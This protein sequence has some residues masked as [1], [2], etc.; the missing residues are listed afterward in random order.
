[1][2]FLSVN[3]IAEAALRFLPIGTP[4]PTPSSG[5]ILS[6]GRSYLSLAPWVT[7]FPGLAIMA[8]VLSLN[9]LGDALRDII[10]PRRR[11]DR[12]AMRRLSRGFP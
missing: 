11:T 9:L 6:D 1:M 2:D 5:N 12:C 3:L 4:P 10:D 8:I 7:G